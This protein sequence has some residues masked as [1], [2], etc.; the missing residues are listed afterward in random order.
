MIVYF[1]ILP[2]FY[3]ADHSRAYNS[4]PNHKYTKSTK[5][6]KDTQEG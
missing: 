3:I 1:D 4:V 5:R 6:T 2:V